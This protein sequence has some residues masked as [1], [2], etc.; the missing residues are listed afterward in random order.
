MKLFAKHVK[1]ILAWWHIQGTERK[2]LYFFAVLFFVLLLRLFFL[3]IVQRDYWWEVLLNQHY[4]KSD[5]VAERWNIFVIDKAWKQLQ[6]TENVEHFTLFADPKFILDKERVIDVLTPIIY[7][8]FC[9][10]YQLEYPD[11]RWCIENLEV[12]TDTPI[13]P[14]RD[15]VFVL[16]GDQ[17]YYV[18]SDEFDEEVQL[19]I[20]WFTQERAYSLIRAK[21]IPTLEWGIKTRNYLWFF[22]NDP[23]LEQL[24]SGRF[25]YIQTQE[26]NYVYIVPDQVTQLNTQARELQ[27]LLQQYGYYY[28]F[29]SIKALLEPQEKRYVRII[30]NMNAK[31]AKMIRDAKTEYFDDLIEWV[32]LLHG[33]WLEEYTKKVLSVLIV[34]VSYY[35]VCG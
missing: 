13:L 32:P 2:L 19:A 17:Q 21:L 14:Q 34:Y 33:L 29:S 15:G 22:D 8:H 18:S 20:D 23:L 3:Q 16:S 11:A 30:T 12:F 6:L 1:K 25:S 28:D 10:I 5:L 9:E 4:T 31:V 27:Q 26:T 35:W 24:E 7:T